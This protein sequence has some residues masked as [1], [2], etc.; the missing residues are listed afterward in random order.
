MEDDSRLK[1]MVQR[2]IWFEQEKS[3]MRLE[4]AHAAMENNRNFKSG[5]YG[6]E[7][8]RNTTKYN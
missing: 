8:G 4:Q 6:S 1:A 3:V 7:V 2:I 5:I